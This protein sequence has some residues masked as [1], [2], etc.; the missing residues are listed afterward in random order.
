MNTVAAIRLIALE[1][2]V[3]ATKF[4]LFTEGRTS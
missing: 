3:G 1:T 4:P 2:D